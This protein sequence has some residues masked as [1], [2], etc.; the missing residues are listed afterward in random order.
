M[1]EIW[2][3]FSI[4]NNYDQPQYNLECWWHK[5]PTLKRIADVVGSTDPFIFRGILSGRKIR[6]NEADYYL[7]KVKANTP[8]EEK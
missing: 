1:N 7:E 4:A 6:W 8:L 3:L 2:C 5:Q